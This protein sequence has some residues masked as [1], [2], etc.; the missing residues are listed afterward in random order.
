MRS[1]IDFEDVTVAPLSGM[2]S[3]LED[4]S[5]G[6]D[7]NQVLSYSQAKAFYDDGFRFVMR[8]VSRN[9]VQGTNDL[10]RNECEDIH[11]A[12]LA[13]GV[14]QHVSPEGW[15][16]SAMKGTDYG[17]NAA[18]Q[19]IN[20]GFPAGMSVW[21]DLEGINPNDPDS[22][23]FASAWYHAVDSYNLNP[24][25]YLGWHDLI[26]GKQAYNLPFKSYWSA[27]NLDGSQFPNPRGVQIRQASERVRH[28]VRYDPDTVSADKMGD[29]P[30]FY[31]PHNA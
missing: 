22:M 8:Y 2:L 11:R 30:W 12:G 14:V 15:D 27:Y 10:T 6:F 28:G 25:I 18:R 16:A 23:A 19:V 26:T 1:R 17:T 20:L 21:C 7:C 9:T 29:R 24:G 5:I 31:L 13:I 3:T 4:G